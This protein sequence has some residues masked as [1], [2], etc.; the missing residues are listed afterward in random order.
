MCMQEHHLDVM[1][2]NLSLNSETLFPDRKATQ[3]INAYERG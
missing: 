2:S 1:N 3:K